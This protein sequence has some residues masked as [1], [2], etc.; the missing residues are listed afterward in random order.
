MFKNQTYYC[1]YCGKEIT[2]RAER[3][4]KRVKTH[5]CNNECKFAYKLNKIEIKGNVT[6]IH[7]KNSKEEYQCI[8]DTYDYLNKIKPLNCTLFAY[9]NYKSK[10]P[11]IYFQEKSTKKKMK[12]HRFLTNCPENM[13]IDHI[14]GNVLDNRQENLRIVDLTINGQIDLQ[15][16]IINHRELEVFI[17]LKNDKNGMV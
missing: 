11:Y 16:A 8:V 17:G 12:L 13:V 3:L 7:V 2:N 4:L 15:V 9:E 1:D 6:I 5:F 10:K 14:N